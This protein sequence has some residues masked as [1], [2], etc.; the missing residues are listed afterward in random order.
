MHLIS[1]RTLNVN[2]WKET[3]LIIISENKWGAGEENGIITGL[4]LH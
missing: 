4:Q 1:S 3:A 2:K